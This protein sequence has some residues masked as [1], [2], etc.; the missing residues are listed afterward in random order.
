MFSDHDD[1]NYDA[2]VDD[3]DVN[4]ELILLGYVQLMN[5][6][7][8]VER[9]SNK[10]KGLEREIDYCRIID[11]DEMKEG[12]VREGGIGETVGVNL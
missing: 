3:G 1:E 11:V 7:K 5:L 12:G 8:E 4:R 9:L 6:T 10:I 2:D